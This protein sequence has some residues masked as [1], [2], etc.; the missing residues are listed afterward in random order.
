VLSLYNTKWR[1]VSEVQVLEEA[2][3][4]EVVVA[5][6]IYLTKLDRLVR[7]LRCIYLPSPY[8]WEKMF[9]KAMD[10]V[11]RLLYGLP[12]DV[13]VSLALKAVSRY[14]PN[15]EFYN[16]GDRRVGRVVEA[17][18]VWLHDRLEGDT[19]LQECQVG[20]RSVPKGYW[21][22]LEAVSLL[23]YTV[24]H[25]SD[26]VER[27]TV[28]TAYILEHCIRQRMDDIW[29]ADNPRDYEADQRILQIDEIL[30]LEGDRLA[31]EE[32]RRLE[33]EMNM[34]LDM[35]ESSQSNN[36]VVR[37]V[38]YRELSILVEWLKEV[39]VSYPEGL[40][41]SRKALRMLRGWVSWDE[42]DRWVR[43]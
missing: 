19:K 11:W 13:Q 34:L 20:N 43:G 7:R 4:V 25:W 14:R 2:K 23:R 33:E 26:E 12:V 1:Y 37:A 18:E 24:L 35:Q 40:R 30:G 38:A 15:Y 5:R 32:K 10:Y 17:I 21:E 39:A 6:H 41:P 36:V 8:D 42:A 3:Q 27:Y 29:R 28:A 22:F 9:T 31:E 16:P